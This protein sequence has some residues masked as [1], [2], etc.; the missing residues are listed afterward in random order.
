MAKNIRIIA[1][2]GWA[3]PE[4]WFSSL[5]K[6]TF[7][8]S[9]ILVHYPKNPSDK[10]EAQVFLEENPCDIYIGYSLGSLWLLK[11]HEYLPKNSSKV[12]IA[13]IINFTDKECGSKFSI[14]QLNLL[15]K[16]IKNKTNHIHYVREFFKLCEIN[17]PESYIQQIPDK[18]ILSQGLAFLLNNS[19]SKNSLDGYL[20]I[21]GSTD[22]LLD[23][24]KI[25]SFMPQ[26]EIIPEIG[27]DPNL[28]LAS[29]S[30]NKLF[31]LSHD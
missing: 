20:G 3:I 19:V 27:H 16:Q 21:I 18:Y 4:K 22:Q 11:N 26:L 7:P 25:K 31:P 14:R 15:I 13:P 30:K 6:N 8:G 5:I 10:E 17:I 1:I 9:D 29:L 23:S 12:L 28:L 2:C 24:A